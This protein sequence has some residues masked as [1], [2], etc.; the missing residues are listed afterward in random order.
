MNRAQ[1]R[2]V[3]DDLIAVALPAI[4]AGLFML[5][6]QRGWLAE[7]G[8]VV[9]IALF[10]VPFALATLLC[11]PSMDDWSYGAAGRQGWWNAQ[12]SMYLGWS[13]RIGATALIS[14]WGQLGSPW[15]AAAVAY[16]C[17][18]AGLFAALAYAIW[19]ISG[20][21]VDPGESQR[22]RWVALAIGA[23]WLAAMPNPNEGLYWLAG[24]AT[25]SAGTSLGIIAIACVLHARRMPEGAGHWRWRT[26]VIAAGAAPLFSEVVAVLVVASLGVL[27]LAI[28]ARHR[29]RI[30]API[31][32][33]T[34]ALVIVALAPGNDVRAAEAA[35]IGQLPG[36]HELIP[37]LQ[38]TGS[39]VV[40]FLSDTGLAVPA[41]LACWI[42]SLTR[43][44]SGRDAAL[45]AVVTVALMAVAALPMAWAGM[46]P[47]RAWNP[48]AMVA[49]IGLM[50]V[51]VRG[52]SLRSVQ[53]GLGLVAGCALLWS[54]RF[55]TESIVVLVGSWTLIGCLIWFVARRHSM[56][57]HIVVLGCVAI[58]LLFGSPRFHDAGRDV[59]VRGAGYE[60]AQWR[61]LSTIAKARSGAHVQVPRLVGDLPHLYHHEDIHIAEATWQNQGQAAFFGLA[62][63]R[64][65]V[66]ADGG[67]NQKLNAPG[68]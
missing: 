61:R 21:L 57:W 11:F 54:Q 55:T 25:Y 15:F 53:I 52:G 14:G 33:A 4:L 65:T 9:A 20:A 46:S 56:T 47:P 63:I 7:R 23:G 2:N 31:A 16:R 12:Q 41:L 8:I 50:A 62:G 48:V 32:A 30:L 51:A 45:I 59:F 38:A 43:P 26:A 22:R 39:L 64:G 68:R 10:I 37:L 29:W 36:S 17:V 18:I 44:G 28:P 13:G 34:L 58:G 19:D 27:V 3:V 49:V 1:S 42:A 66:T 5:L 6:W 60:S 24:A 40:G 35:R 67:L